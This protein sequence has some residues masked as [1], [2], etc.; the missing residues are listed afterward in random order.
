MVCRFE[1]ELKITKSLVH[2]QFRSHSAAITQDGRV[3]VF[4]RTHGFK[5]TM[6]YIQMKRLFSPIVSL[7]NTLG[8]GRNVEYFT[9]VWVSL[10]PNEIASKV[11]CSA[12]LTCIM[13]QSGRMYSFGSNNY[14]QCGI[15]SESMHA[16]DPTQVLGL[17]DEKVVDIA[18]GYQHVIAATKSGRVF[19]WGK[20]ERGQLGTGTVNQMQA[21][22]VE[23]P[24]RTKIK[25][26][27]AGFNQSAAL[28]QDGDLFVWGKLLAL[29]NRSGFKDQTVP[30]K[31]KLRSR[32]IDMKASQFHIMFRTEDNKL[33]LVGR[34]QNHSK[35]VDG[36]LVHVPAKMLVEPT[37]IALDSDL[38]IKTLCRG[39][40]STSFIT[41]KCE[42]ATDRISS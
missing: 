7:M 20:G 8:Q 26:V 41:G 36:K 11:S 18:A 19:S 6:R 31:L 13:M 10:P 9:P 14:G 21:E 5:N 4:G 28:S 42:I 37:P 24:K 16:W 15:G 30:R 1:T 33:W 12:A 3:A 22:A 39:L 23:F 38:C 2:I 34:Q 40:D 27:D 17:E 25:T 32:V 29:P 35:L